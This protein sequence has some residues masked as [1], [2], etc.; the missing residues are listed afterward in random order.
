M[1]STYFFYLYIP[2]V[3]KSLF[4]LGHF[5]L[6]LF[7]CFCLLFHL[8]P[9]LLRLLAFLLHGNLQF[10]HLPLQQISLLC[11]RDAK[12]LKMKHKFC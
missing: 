6:L 5:L 8:P 4:L 9:L 2:I 3:T 12:R 11:V 10:L 1:L 7:S